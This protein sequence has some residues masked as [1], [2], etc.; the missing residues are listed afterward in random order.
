MDIKQ[1]YREETELDVFALTHETYHVFSNEY[2][3][4]LEK[5][6]LLPIVSQRSKLVAI[7]C[8]HCGRLNNDTMCKLHPAAC[9]N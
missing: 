6:L 3:N 2:V 7:G 5:Q 1:K 4:W 8:T 9:K